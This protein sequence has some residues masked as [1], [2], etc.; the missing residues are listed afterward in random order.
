M[1]SGRTWV[2]RVYSAANE[3]C[4]YVVRSTTV[5]YAIVEVACLYVE[6]AGEGRALSHGTM[7]HVILHDFYALS[8]IS[9]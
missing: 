2:R 1:G 8:M 3:G 6:P 9:G 5:I 7:V 4:K